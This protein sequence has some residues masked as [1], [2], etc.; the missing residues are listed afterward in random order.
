MRASG[1]ERGEGSELLDALLLLLGGVAAAACEVRE[2]FCVVVFVVAEVE[3]KGGE[4]WREGGKG[5]GEG[6]SGLDWGTVRL[7][8]KTLGSLRLLVFFVILFY[9]FWKKKWVVTYRR[10]FFLG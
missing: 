4:E 10:R 9:Y 5:E 2:F 3:A 7:Y 1:S 6:R 8:S